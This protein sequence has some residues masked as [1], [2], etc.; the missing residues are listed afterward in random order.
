MLDGRGVRWWVAGGCADA[1]LG[2]RRRP[3]DLDLE[4]AADDAPRMAAALGV[5]FASDRDASAS[6]LRARRTLAGVPLDVTAGLHV[7]GRGGELSP[8]DDVLWQRAATV[9]HC[10]MAVRVLAPDE[11]VAR[12][13]AWGDRGRLPRAGAAVDAGYVA[14]RLGWSSAAVYA[15]LCDETPSA[16]AASATARGPSPAPV[17]TST[18]RT[19][20]P[21]SGSSSAGHSTSVTSPR[22]DCA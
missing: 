18:T 11:A 14:R 8:A 9:W 1:L 19:S 16:A 2:A 20:A 3:A 6:S 13:L 12:A 15:A 5:R 10:G 4:C 21:S 17:S 22:G 7:H